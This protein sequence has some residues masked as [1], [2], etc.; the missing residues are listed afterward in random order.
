MRSR[1]FIADGQVCHLKTTPTSLALGKW[2]VAC[3]AHD[4][5]HARM[6]EQMRVD[7]RGVAGPAVFG[8]A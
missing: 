3:A 2:E 8:R 5:A 1:F 6:A 7:G 4:L